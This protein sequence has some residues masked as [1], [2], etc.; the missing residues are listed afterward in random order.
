MK[1]LETNAKNAEKAMAILTKLLI[2]Q[3]LFALEYLT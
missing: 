3:L 1:T 2:S